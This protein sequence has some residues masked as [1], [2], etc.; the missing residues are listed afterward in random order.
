MNVTISASH[1]EM[2]VGSPGQR[3]ERYI[4]MYSRQAI[5]RATRRYIYI[6]LY[7]LSV[8][9]RRLHCPNPRSF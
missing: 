3:D 1:E 8:T 6:Y 5:L 7:S 4:S 2:F 9:A